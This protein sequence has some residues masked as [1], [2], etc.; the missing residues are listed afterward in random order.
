MYGHKRHRGKQIVSVEVHMNHNHTEGQ[1][2]VKWVGVPEQLVGYTCSS[3]ITHHIRLHGQV[4]R[5]VN[6]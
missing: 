5:Q 3:S 2:R 6:R 1:F 4:N